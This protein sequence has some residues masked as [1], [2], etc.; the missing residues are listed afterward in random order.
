MANTYKALSTVTVG[1]GGAASMSFTNI[2]QTYTDLVLKVSPRNTGSGAGDSTFLVEFNGSS[3]SYS[4]RS[5]Y[6]NGS[7]VSGF[8]ESTPEGY[9]NVVGTWTGNMYGNNEIY[10]SN[11][12][13]GN[14]KAFSIDGAGENNAVRADISAGAFLWSNTSPITSIIVKSYA[15]FTF[16]QYTTATLYGVF[17]AD[18]STAPATPTI[19][20]A[21]A[22]TNTDA[23]IT[24]T[25]VSNAA[26]YTMTSTPDSI[27]ATG[28]TSPITVTGLTEGTSYTFKV[29]SNNPFGS[30]AESAA[31]NSI[32][33]VTPASFEFIASTTLTSSASTITFTGLPQTY[34]R[35][36][37]RCVLVPTSNAAS[38]MLFFNND[39]AGGNYGAGEAYAVYNGSA[40]G[41]ISLA[42]NNDFPFIGTSQ[43]LYTNYGGA[44]VIDIERYTDTSAYTTY[45]A[46]SGFTYT[47]SESYKSEI[48]RYYGIWKSTAAV[49]RLDFLFYSGLANFAAGTVISIYGVKG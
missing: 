38:G 49:T 35:L 13:S 17:N 8:G 6:S 25:G 33:A 16:A 27:A 44:S 42:Y 32:T 26:S 9:G 45:N 24:F 47:S 23:S 31:S 4:G 46:L 10:I 14:Y 37:V 11:Y 18:V 5:L 39:L 21:T 12:T 3:S 1:A 22:G 43:G 41:N 20:T 15:A 34:T 19:G 40:F 36:Q 7:A 30:S 2:P 29:K 48:G 28:T